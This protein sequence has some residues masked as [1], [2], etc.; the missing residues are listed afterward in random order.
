MRESH[1]KSACMSGAA[2]AGELEPS[3]CKLNLKTR[4]ADRLSLTR[5]AEAQRDQRLGTSQLPGLVTGW[6]RAAVTN[7]HSHRMFCWFSLCG[8][9]HGRR[10]RT[11]TPEALYTVFIHPAAREGNEAA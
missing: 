9:F 6:A 1:D 4:D 3:S 5:Q 8:L 11:I 7:G 10:G 2:A